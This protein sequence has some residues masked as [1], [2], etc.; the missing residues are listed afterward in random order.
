MAASVAA[1]CLGALLAVW[2]YTGAST[3]QSV[4]AVRTTVHRGELITRA[5]LMTARIGVDPVL[6]PLPAS[7]AESVVGKRAAMDLAAGGLVTQE[8]IAS[9]LVP[10]KGMSVVGVSL[11][12]ALMPA[13]QLQS[14]DRVRIGAPPGAQ[15]AVATESSP[16]SLGA[17]GVAVRGAGDTGQIVVDVS[18]PYDQAAELAARAATGKVALVLDSRER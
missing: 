17:A 15:G 11:P 18:V 3:S 16:E 9:A 1:I 7:A 14:G 5:D 10:A 4:L 12:P 8:D 13:T 2:A 6:K